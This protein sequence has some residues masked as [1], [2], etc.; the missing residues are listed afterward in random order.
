MCDR[1]WGT[2][3]QIKKW[4][5]GR[6]SYKLLYRT[7]NEWEDLIGF[8]RRSGNGQGLI[9]S[10][11][12]VL[13]E[14]GFSYLCGFRVSP[15]R[16]GSYGVVKAPFLMMGLGENGEVVNLLDPEGRCDLDGE[17]LLDVGKLGFVESDL[18]SVNVSFMGKNHL[19]VEENSTRFVGWNSGVS[20]YNKKKNMM[21]RSSSSGSMKFEE[22]EVGADG[23]FVGSPGSFPDR[24]MLDIYQYFA[25]RTSPV[26]DRTS[27]RQRRK[28]KERRKWGAEHFVKIVNCSPTHDRPLQ[29]LWKVFSILIVKRYY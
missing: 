1:R 15:S 4:G 21:S 14:W 11:G 26:S 16:D 28:E 27:R 13:F 22:E 29:G 17:E 10:P 2:K 6:V 20:N 9:E 8:W 25:N 7:L 12:L 3:T 18:I 5:G 24:L 19:V 23:G